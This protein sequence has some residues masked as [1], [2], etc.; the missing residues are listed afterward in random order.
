MLPATWMPTKAQVS[1]LPETNYV[2][3]I[4]LIWEGSFHMEEKG[5]CSKWP[6]LGIGDHGQEAWGLLY[7]HQFLPLCL[8]VFAFC[9]WVLLCWVC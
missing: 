3:K 4:D 8:L 7:S 5:L 6:F 2:W 9:I 1:D